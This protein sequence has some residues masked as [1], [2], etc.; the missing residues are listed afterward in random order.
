MANDIHNEFV[1]LDKNF[2]KFT[3]AN[4]PWQPF[5]T[6]DKAWLERG[7]LRSIIYQKGRKENVGY[8]KICRKMQICILWAI[9]AGLDSVELRVKSS[10]PLLKPLIAWRWLPGNL[11]V[12]HNGWAKR[13][14]TGS[15]GNRKGLKYTCN[16]L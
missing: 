1:V 6:L 5:V 13:Q 14:S 7:V 11:S 16:Y 10:K 15:C 9:K 8:F 3:I 2:T 4:I 12:R